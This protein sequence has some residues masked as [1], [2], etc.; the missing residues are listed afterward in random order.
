MKIFQFETLDSTSSHA[1]RLIEGGEKPPF[2]VISLRQTEGRG[3]SGKTWSSPEGGLYL[4]VVFDSRE[5]AHTKQGQWPL[6]AATAVAMWLRQEFS[7]RATIKW[8]NDILYAGQK[9]AGILCESSVQGD[10]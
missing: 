1:S 2:A 6:L 5:L 9:L 3:R 7:F 4:T 10:V 8:P